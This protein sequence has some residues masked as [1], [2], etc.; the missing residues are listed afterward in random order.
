[1]P[2]WPHSVTLPDEDCSARTFVITG[3]AIDKGVLTFDGTTFTLITARS[4]DVGT[5]T[6]T[7]TANIA[8]FDFLGTLL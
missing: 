3:T 1:M 7:V 4:I 8:G 6:V 5:S 2:T